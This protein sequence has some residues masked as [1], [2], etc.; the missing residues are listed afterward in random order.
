MSEI[1]TQE[2]LLPETLQASV[3]KLTE[4]WETRGKMR[5]LWEADESLWTSSGEA[6]WLGWLPVG[7]YQRREGS[8]SLRSF[9]AQVR[10][11]YSHAVLLGMGGSS[12]CPEV[13]RRSFGT[14]EGFPDLRVLDSTDPAQ[15][16]ACENSVRLETTLFLA[17]S[18]SGTTLET[19][20]LTRYFLKRLSDRIGA[21][22]AAARFVA[23]T[24]PGSQLEANAKELGFGHVLYGIPAIG[25]RY[26]ALSHFG[27][28]PAAAMGLDVDELLRSAEAMQAACSPEARSDAN[29]SLQL[30]LLLGAAAR[31]GRD[32]LTFVAT[33]GVFALGAW[34]EQ[35]VAE[36]TGKNGTGIVPIEGEP[37]GAPSSYGDDRVFV[38]LRL[39]SERDASRDAALAEL[40]GRGHPVVRITIPRVEE[41]GQEFFRWELAT[42][43]AGS[44]LGINPFDQPDVEASKGAARRLTAAYEAE[45]SLPA[46]EAFF[47]NDGIL[48][49]ASRDYAALLTDTV[50]EATLAALLRSHL[51]TSGAGDYVA[52]LAYLQKTPLVEASLG[53]IRR[54]VRV[55]R[56]VATCLGFGPRF[57]HSTGQLHKGGAGNGVFL[58]IGCDD[59]RDLP[60]PGR[61]LSF[62]VVKAAQARGDFDVLLQLRRRAL[63]LHIR[64]DL[65]EGLDRLESAFG[66][67]TQ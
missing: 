50:A 9:A 46:E 32:K 66:R 44:V 10:G 35:L 7:R 36:S 60:V 67:A 57:L 22:Q 23:I 29:P 52:L 47:E 43:V 3:W 12:L 53:R 63:R 19:L 8:R 45:G 21:A 37:L 64:G 6:E 49:F 25:G 34:I 40:H 41:I 28:A 30:G 26:S 51:N 39:D 65:A 61:S 20:L 48:L 4:E 27:M 38:H 55:S 5:R 18:K 2:C 33:P 17:A 56:P 42:A 59:K 11:R 58:Q 54:M 31:E 15:I 1:N 16:Q 13:L 62:G 14:R 24:D